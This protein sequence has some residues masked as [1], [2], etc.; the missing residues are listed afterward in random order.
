MCIRDR[1]TGGEKFI[2]LNAFCGSREAWEEWSGS[3]SRAMDARGT[4]AEMDGFGL[5]IS[6]DH[7][8]VR[9]NG[10]MIV[11]RELSED[12]YRMQRLKI[13]SHPIPDD[14][15]ELPLQRSAWCLKMGMDLTSGLPMLSLIH[16]FFG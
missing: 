1:Y 10:R 3:Y 14:L 13:S 5:L 12:S 9:Q 16:I 15:G 8:M 7:Q 6:E 11:T 2:D 4:L